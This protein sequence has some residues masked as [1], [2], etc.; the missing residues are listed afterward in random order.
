[1]QSL[2]SALDA[3]SSKESP[4]MDLHRVF[5]DVELT[6]DVALDKP[7]SSIKINCFWRLESLVSLP[8]VA[9]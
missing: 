8:A 2:S 6:G 4:K 5:T 3:Q 1:M 9:G 7:R